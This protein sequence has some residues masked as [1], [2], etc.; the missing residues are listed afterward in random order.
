MRQKYLHLDPNRYSAANAQGTIKHAIIEKC[1]RN[2]FDPYRFVG[3]DFRLGDFREDDEDM[4]QEWA[5]YLYEFTED[6]ADTMSIALDEIDK[7]EGDKYIEFRVDLSEI[8]GDGQF[9]TLD[10]AIVIPLGGNWYDVLIWDNKFGRVAVDAVE[11]D[12]LRLY[13]IGFYFNILREMNIRIR[14][15]IIRIWQPYVK[16]GGGEW[17]ISLPDLL[18]F[19]KSAKIAAKAALSPSSIAVPGPEQCEWCIGA[20]LS[21]CEA[22]FNWNKKIL[23][24]MFS[25]DENLENLVDDDEIPCLKFNGVDAKLRTWI[26]NN[27]PMFSKFVERLEGQAFEDAYY[28]RDV[29]GKKLVKGHSPR[30]KYKDNEAAKTRIVSAI[31]ESRAFTKKLISPAQLEKVVGKKN[32]GEYEEFIDRGEAKLV[33]VDEHDSRP[34]I[35]SIRDMFEDE[36]GE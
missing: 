14:K 10:L 33:L 17:D 4:P 3:M 32:M 9:G 20:K 8:C 12:Q 27:F 6:D 21:K 34:R 16:G 31:G 19:G 11:N 36:D 30:R 13:A 18:T 25:D 26:I 2:D 28:G 35:K 5:D 22:N 23:T 1:L 7:Y 29:P 15:F 24:S